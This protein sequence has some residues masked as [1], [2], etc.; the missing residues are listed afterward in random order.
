MEVQVNTGE[1]IENPIK[2]A[3]FEFLDVFIALIITLTM[4]FVNYWQAGAVLIY[5]GGVTSVNINYDD[6]VQQ[7]FSTDT[8]PLLPLR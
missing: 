4:F 6:A 7:G 1:I 5:F 8:I 3:L 2:L